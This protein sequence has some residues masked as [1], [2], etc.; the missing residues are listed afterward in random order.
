M[1]F[2][3]G[4]E[5]KISDYNFAILKTKDEDGNENF[6]KLIMNNEENDF[7]RIVSVD[8]IKENELT[9]NVN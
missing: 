5:E 2:N 7:I 6:F 8:Y 4:T 3:I 9:K 1:V